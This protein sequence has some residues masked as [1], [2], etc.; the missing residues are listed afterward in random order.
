M[1]QEMVLEMVICKAFL[2]MS[3]LQYKFY[4]ICYTSK[5]NSNFDDS[6][7][8]VASRWNRLCD[9][10]YVDMKCYRFLPTESTPTRFFKKIL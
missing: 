5:Y 8:I 3:T 1:I 10:D 6:T 4:S 2:W 7:T 9:I